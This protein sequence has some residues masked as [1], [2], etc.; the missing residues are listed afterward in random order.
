NLLLLA[1]TAPSARGVS[2]NDFVARTYTD[3]N[4]TIPYR[5]FIP[6]NYTTSSN[7]PIVLYLHGAGERGNDNSFQLVGETA[8]L[9]FAQETNQAI[10]PSFMVAPQ[11]PA[12]A[13][14]T[15]NNI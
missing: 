2:V 9:V 5:L 10:R 11:C 15:N 14:W 8:Q 6:A 12:G 4:G 3:T 7:Y 13:D 1:I